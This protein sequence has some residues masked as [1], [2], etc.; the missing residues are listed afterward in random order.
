MVAERDGFFKCLCQG[1]RPVKC[2][3]EEG[4]NLS[5]KEALQYR[6]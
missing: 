5:V 4:C 3:L 2:K 1:L 6:T